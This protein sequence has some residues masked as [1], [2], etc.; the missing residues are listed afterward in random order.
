MAFVLPP[1]VKVSFMFFASSCPSVF[2]LSFLMAASSFSHANKKKQ[3]AKRAALKI[4]YVDEVFKIFYSYEP[5]A[6]SCE[7]CYK[8]QA[9]F[10]N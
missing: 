3:P 10:P 5:L 8:L 9:S 2:E 4:L 7:H 1:V 6:A